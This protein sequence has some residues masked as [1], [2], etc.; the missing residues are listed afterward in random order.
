[1]PLS[2]STDLRLFEI[3][4]AA[5]LPALQALRLVNTALDALFYDVGVLSTA[6]FGRGSVVV[7]AEATSASGAT[8]VSRRFEFLD[9]RALSNPEGCI[10]VVDAD[11][12]PYVQRFLDVNE[13]L[14]A[15]NRDGLE[16]DT[17][18][19]TGV[20]SSALGSAAFAWNASAALGRAVAAVVP[21]YGLADVMHQALGGW[22]GFGLTDWIERRSQEV[23]ATV[24]P[25]LAHV[26]HGMLASAPSGASHAATGAPV[27][28]TGNAASDIVHSILQNAPGIVNLIGHSKGSLAIGNA[29]RSLPPGRAASLAV[30]TFGCPI[31]EVVEVA[32]Y[33]QFLGIFDGLGLL[34]SWGNRPDARIVSHHSTNTLI[35]LSMLIT[36]LIRA[37]LDDD[38]AGTT[39]LPAPA[40]ASTAAGTAAPFGS[41]SKRARQPA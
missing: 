12:P 27:F 34:N 17:L 23:L 6:L 4:P 35:P 15:M 10:L 41:P 9:L 2:P 37:A 5:V 3:P 13:F 33:R 39:A 21:G 29:I 36:L 14:A 30:V 11:K 40:R 22:F 7:A 28:R 31:A 1:M 24:A 32:R 16:I 20:G 25:H 8:D 38:S 26:G 19:V 18:T